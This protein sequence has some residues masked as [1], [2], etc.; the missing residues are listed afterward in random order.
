MKK[1]RLFTAKGGTQQ[2][3]ASKLSKM[4]SGGGPA[5]KATS[6]GATSGAKAKAAPYRKMM[7][8]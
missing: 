4:S 1:H 8:M 3:N 2:S 7:G 6:P 5:A